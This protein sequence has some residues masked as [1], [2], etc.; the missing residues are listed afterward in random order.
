MVKRDQ[1]TATVRSIWNDNPNVVDEEGIDRLYELLVPLTQVDAATKAAHVAAITQQYNSNERVDANVELASS[2]ERSPQ[3]EDVACD[4]SPVD[5]TVADL[6]S[7]E[8]DDLTD[9]DNQNDPAVFDRL[10]DL[11]SSGELEEVVTVGTTNANGMVDTIGVVDTTSTIG[12]ADTTDEIVTSG[13]INKIT[14]STQDAHA[15][16]ADEPPISG[17]KPNRAPVV[18]TSLSSA[19]PRE[20]LMLATSFTGAAIFPSVAIRKRLR[21]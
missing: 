7:P 16:V 6:E 1:L 18:E 10:S 14:A 3:A 13:T 2:G 4:T 21:G 19:P 11:I 17:Q 5:A 20:D 8:P 15:Q 12:T 9:A